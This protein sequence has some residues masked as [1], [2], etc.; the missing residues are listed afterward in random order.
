MNT[1]TR[2]V[3]FDAAPDDPFAPTCTPIYQ[4]ATFEQD[5]PECFGR[6]DY[7]RSGNPTRGVLERL[8]ADLEGGTRAFAFAS[9]LAA[10][11]AVTRLLDPGDEILACDDLYG[12]AYRLFTKLLAPRGVAVRFVDFTAD[13]PLPISPRTKLVYF[14]TPSN[15]RLRITDIRRRCREAREAGALSCVDGTATTPYLQKPL[16]LGADIVLHSATKYLAGH[17][18][19]T[20]GAVIVKDPALADRLYLIQNGEGAVLG[21]FD[22]FLLLRG[23][24]TLAL[25]LDRQQ[26][27]AQRI[28]EWLDR[29]PEVARVHFPGLHTHPG[30]DLHRSQSL[31]P[32]AVLSFEITDA[33]AAPDLVRGLSLF[34]TTVSFGAVGSS[35]SIPA[36]MSHAPIAVDAA[37]P[38]VAPPPRGL[39]RLS[40]G[41]EDPG[42]LI[43]DLARAFEVVA[44]PRHRDVPRTSGVDAVSAPIG[45]AS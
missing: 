28:A 31:G 3:S 18:D 13:A 20:A 1:A 32:G 44:E 10:I 38:A 7:S 36:C 9:G 35:A 29:R 42:D 39:I 8:L 26:A 22:S 21:P 16:E 41:I 34:R 6:F 43:A 45:A 24:K 40:V 27:S 2:L 11:T 30:G 5:S 12:G 19:V 4:T 33:T 15:P 17:A 37:G 23:I 14:E 25:R